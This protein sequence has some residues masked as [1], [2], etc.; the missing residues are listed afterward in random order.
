LRWVQNNVAQFGGDPGNV[1]V[2]GQSG[3]GAK[4]ATLLASP[5]SKGL[6]HKAIIQS[7]APGSVPSSYSNPAVARRVA[8]LTFQQAGLGAEQ[9]DQL[10]SIPYDRLIAAANKA[11]ELVGKESAPTAGRFGLS[12]ERWRRFFGQGYKWISG[13]A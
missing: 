2:F 11:L 13:R 5:K 3:G 7:G 6:F 9:V 10:R 1:T 4:V 8:A 12:W